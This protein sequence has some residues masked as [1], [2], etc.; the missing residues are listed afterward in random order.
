VITADSELVKY[1]KSKGWEWGGDCWADRV[2]Y[3]HF[4]K[5]LPQLIKSQGTN[6]FEIDI[7]PDIPKAEY[8]RKQL[9]GI[10]P[11][12]FFVLGGGN[13]E[14]KNSEGR[15]SYKTSPYRGKFFPEKTG[16]A[17]A[18]P[19][20]G[21]ELSSYYPNATIV[22][23]SHRPNN[24]FMLSEQS[25]QQSTDYPTFAHVLSDDMQRAG[26]DA[27]RII[28]KPRSTSTLTEIIEV[29]KLTA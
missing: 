13:R 2:D 22:T 14:I 4:A 16:G 18:R 5:P 11:D 9:D 29:I 1:F 20:S 24:L 12:A 6:V 3:M 10:T 27:G 26:V 17:K 25:T 23:L 28:E 15:K 19:I 8:Y 21:I 7:D